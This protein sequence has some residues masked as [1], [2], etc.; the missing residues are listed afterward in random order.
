M[1]SAEV[2][3]SAEAAQASHQPMGL[4]E[5]VV[6]ASAAIAI[7][8][9][10]TSIMLAALPDIAAAY[11]L[12]NANAHQLVLTILFAGFSLGQFVAGPISGRF[13]RRSVLIAGLALSALA[14]LVCVVAPSLTNLL[15]PRGLIQSL[16]SAS[17]HI[18]MTSA[19]RDCYGGRWMASLMSR[20]TNVLFAAPIP[21][22]V[23]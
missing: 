16:A 8:A 13:G 7:N 9:L 20:V 10:A 2:V 12:K 15:V 22:P 11:A 21:H 14:S 17:L 6:F 3:R 1:S 5:L 18:V 19:V 4:T 23:P